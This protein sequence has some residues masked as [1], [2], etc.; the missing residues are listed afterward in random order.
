MAIAI[1]I[2]KKYKLPSIDQI[3][4]KIIQVRDEILLKNAVFWDVMP[5]GSCKNRRFGGTSVLT[6]AT[7]RNI[8]DDGILHS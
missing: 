6:K 3:P 7:R 1:A 8:P 2:L 5:C 4:T